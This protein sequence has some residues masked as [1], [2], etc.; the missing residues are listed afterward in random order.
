MDSGAG[1]AAALNFGA[2]AVWVGTRF[3]AAEEAGA[4]QSPFQNCQS[5]SDLLPPLP[6]KLHQEAVTTGQLVLSYS[7]PL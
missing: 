3:V 2:T 5:I 1:L 7:L 4:S 6:G